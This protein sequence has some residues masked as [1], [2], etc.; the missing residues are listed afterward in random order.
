MS[1][2]RLALALRYVTWLD[3]HRRAVLAIAAAVFMAS[4]WLVATR[5]PVRADLSYLLPES[6]RSVRDLRTLERRLA[7][8]DA[9][10]VVVKSADPQARAA[11][12]AELATAARGFAQVP[13]VRHR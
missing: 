11:V 1:V 6:A 9:V 10:L 13:D 2:P 7:V 4:A 5:L 12:A 3:R 8:Q